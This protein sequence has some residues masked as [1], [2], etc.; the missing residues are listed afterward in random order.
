LRQDILDFI[1]YRNQTAKPIHWT[2]TAEKLEQR[3]GAN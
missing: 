1:A 3:L 2:Y